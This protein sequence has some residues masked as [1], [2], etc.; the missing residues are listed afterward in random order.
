M[1][2]WAQIT[3]EALPLKDFKPKCKSAK[4]AEDVTPKHPHDLRGKLLGRCRGCKRYATA[5]ACM[6]VVLRLAWRGK[7]ASERLRKTIRR[8]LY[9]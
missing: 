5:D 3:G 4:L 1:C 2:L 7:A 6:R 8:H 9:S